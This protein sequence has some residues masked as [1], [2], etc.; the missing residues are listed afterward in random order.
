MTDTLIIYV[1]WAPGSA[2]ARLAE[3]IEQHFS[4][5]GMERDGVSHRVPVRFRSVPFDPSSGPEPVAIDLNLAK[6]N[7]VVLLHDAAMAHESAMWGPY[8]S[9]LRKRMDR[10]GDVDFYIPFQGDR[11]AARLPDDAARTTNYAH[12]YKWLAWLITPEASDQHALLFLLHT[13]RKRLK[14]STNQAGKKETIFVSH[15]KLDGDDTARAIL[16][17]VNADHQDIPLSLFYDAKQ[18]SP[19]DDFQQEFIDEIGRGTLLAIVSDA[20]DSRPWCVFELTE[21]KKA[22]R[23]IILADLGRR[24]ISRTYPYGANLPRVKVN[25]VDAFAIES[26]MVEVL[27]EGLRCDLF[28]D[29][30]EEALQRNN[31]RGFVLPRPPELL[32]FAIRTFDSSLSIIVYPD[33]PLPTIEQDLIAT[34]MQNASLTLELKTLGELL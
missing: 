9:E 13:L 30:A 29:S 32:D 1:L 33:P 22:R 34:A 12:Q 15:A 8:V 31:A 5:L 4:G 7:A 6:H 24:R 11:A 28:V 18:L 16:R 2:C 17:Y 21:A 23:P 27:S 26:L 10:R 19:G 3:R 14:Q 25:G 20:Y